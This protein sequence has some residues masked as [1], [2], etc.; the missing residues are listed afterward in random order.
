MQRSKYWFVRVPRSSDVYRGIISACKAC[1]AVRF[2]KISKYPDFAEVYLSLSH[3]VRSS[4]LAAYF[5]D[6]FFLPL[7]CSLEGLGEL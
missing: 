5:D 3:S 2:Y 1:K 6:A 4:Q 7:P